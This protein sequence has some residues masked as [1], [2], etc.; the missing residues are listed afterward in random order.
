MHEHCVV[1]CASACGCEHVLRQHFELVAVVEV[2]VEV[3]VVGGVRSRFW[4]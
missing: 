3:V 4:L 2:V 1:I